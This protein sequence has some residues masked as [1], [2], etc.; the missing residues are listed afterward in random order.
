MELQEPT[1]PGFCCDIINVRETGISVILVGGDG[2]IRL[3]A[4]KT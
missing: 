4:G 1:E 2:N 3:S